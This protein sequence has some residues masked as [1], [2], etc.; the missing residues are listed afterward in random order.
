LWQWKILLNAGDIISFIC[1]PTFLFPY[2]G[3]RLWCRR[4]CYFLASLHC[5]WTVICHKQFLSYP[6]QFSTLQFSFSPCIWEKR[7]QQGKQSVY[8]GYLENLQASRSVQHRTVE[9]SVNNQ[10][11]R[12]ADGKGHDLLRNTLAALA[13]GDSA[14]TPKISVI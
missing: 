5:P 11:K 1:Y 9:W 3:D 8:L 12:D 2:L 6:I 4:I 10:L 7:R 13:Q 14:P